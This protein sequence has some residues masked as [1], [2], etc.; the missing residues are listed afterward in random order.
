MGWRRY[1]AKTVSA[2]TGAAAGAGVTVVAGPIGGAAA[3]AVVQQATESMLDELI[4]AQNDHLQDLAALNRE[5]RDRL[6]GVQASVDT[7]IDGP[8]RTARLYIEEAARMHDARQRGNNLE[9]ARQRLYD[10]WGMANNAMRR[11]A[12]AQELSALCALI[13][14]RSGVERWL[15]RAS[16]NSDE[17]VKEQSREVLKDRIESWES[18][19]NM[20]QNHLTLT[21]RSPQSI[22]RCL[23]HTFMFQLPQLHSR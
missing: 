16:D 15:D 22:S 12:V 19:V 3:G 4:A 1:L 13:N 7:I 8:W 6:I 23:D 9:L 2:T 20:E 11:S 10:A 5:L 21:L 17:A 18:P 14:D